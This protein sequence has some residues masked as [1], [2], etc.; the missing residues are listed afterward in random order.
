PETTIRYVLP[1]GVKVEMSVYDVAGQRVR[2]LIDGR[3]ASGS[4]AAVWDGRDD[5]GR[6]VGSG[7]YL[8]RLQAGAFEQSRKIVLLK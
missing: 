8:V 4:Y 1:V 5:A 6:R 3:Q 2:L 7:T